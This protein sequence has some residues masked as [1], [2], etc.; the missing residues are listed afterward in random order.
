MIKDIIDRYDYIISKYDNLSDFMNRKG[1]AYSNYYS[2]NLSALTSQLAKQNSDIVIV[3]V[4]ASLSLAASA[5][6]FVIKKKKTR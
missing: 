6:F 1:A 3:I 4:S 2:N 5:V